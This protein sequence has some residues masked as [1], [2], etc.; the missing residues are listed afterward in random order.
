MFVS[1][2]GLTNGGQL[3]GL[4]IPSLEQ[5][6]RSGHEV[7]AAQEALRMTGQ[8]WMAEIRAARNEEREDCSAMVKLME[9]HCATRLASC[10]VLVQ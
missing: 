3:A 10:E 6:K 9:E 7:V 2:L 5:A 8:E 4:T 1:A